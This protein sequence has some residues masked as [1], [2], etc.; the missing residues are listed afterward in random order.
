MILL[1]SIKSRIKEG[2]SWGA[3]IKVAD[4]I[5]ADNDF[6]GAAVNRSPEHRVFRAEISC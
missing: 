1:I 6:Q 5:D 2:V 4:E 3:I